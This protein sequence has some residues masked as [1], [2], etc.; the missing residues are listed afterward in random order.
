MNVDE[1]TVVHLDLY[2]HVQTAKSVGTGQ[3]P[4]WSAPNGRQL[5][6]I[7]PNRPDADVVG[8]DVPNAGPGSDVVETPGGGAGQPGFSDATS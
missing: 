3:Q 7:E 2:K 8:P 6:P 4:S 1:G 5:A